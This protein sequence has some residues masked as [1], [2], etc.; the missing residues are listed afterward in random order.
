MD[1]L[2]AAPAEVGSDLDDPVNDNFLDSL[3]VHLVNLLLI[4]VPLQ[5]PGIG[6]DQGGLGGLAEVL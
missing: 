5:Q 3:E 2:V 6:L 1:H 4:N